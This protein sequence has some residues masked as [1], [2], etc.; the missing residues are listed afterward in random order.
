MG[1]VAAAGRGGEEGG[2]GGFTLAFA[3]EGVGEGGGGG[4]GGGMV[5]PRVGGILAVVRLLVLVF[6]LVFLVFLRHIHQSRHPPSLFQQGIH[7][8]LMLLLL[9]LL[10]T[11]QSPSSPSP[12]SPSSSNTT[13]T[14]QT[15]FQLLQFLAHRLIISLEP[16]LSLLPGALG[17]EHLDLARADFNLLGPMPVFDGVVRI[18]EN[19][20]ARVDV[21]EHNYFALAFERRL[22]GRGG[23]GGREGGC[24]RREID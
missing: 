2:G 3:V 23:E 1:C 15:R 20:V 16:R 9:L 19:G 6:L 12:S 4:G 14:K 13:T 8:I 5:E 10:V 22:R 11:M 17:Y 21:H 7:M 18:V 24:E